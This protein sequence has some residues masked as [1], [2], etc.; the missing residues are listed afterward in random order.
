MNGIYKNVIMGDML[1][2]SNL[3]QINENETW[4]GPFEATTYYFRMCKIHRKNWPDVVPAGYYK[5]FAEIFDEN[6]TPIVTYTLTI[7]VESLISGFGV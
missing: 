5:F 4:T 6:D 2:C 1:S 7:E 3:P